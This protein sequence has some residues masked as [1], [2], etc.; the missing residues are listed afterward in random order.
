MSSRSR[1]W[2]LGAGAGAVLSA[3]WIAIPEVPPFSIQKRV[4]QVTGLPL[5]LSTPVLKRE[6]HATRYG[7]ESLERVELQLSPSGYAQLAST[8]HQHALRRLPAALPLQSDPAAG[9]Y[10][11]VGDPEDYYVRTVLD[12]ATRRLQVTVLIR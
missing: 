11:E 10:R 5:A 9:Y 7:S 1:R 3:A 12:E 8:A 4:R 6:V 2:W